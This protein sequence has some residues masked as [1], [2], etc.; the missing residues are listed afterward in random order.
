[1]VPGLE[2]LRVLGPGDPLPFARLIAPAPRHRGLAGLR[3][4]PLDVRDD[5]AL[6][7]LAPLPDALNVS[8]TPRPAR[9][10][11]GRHHARLGRIDPREYGGLT[12]EIEDPHGSMRAFYARLAMVA[13]GQPVLARMSVYGTSINGADRTTAQLRQLLQARFGGGGKGWVPAAP[14]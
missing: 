3:Q 1:L 13:R 5:D 14:G 4:R 12:R 6:L 11:A 10:H 2:R 7:E 9:R 8:S